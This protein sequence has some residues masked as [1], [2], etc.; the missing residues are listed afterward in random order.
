MMAA[1]HLYSCSEMCVYW[2]RRVMKSRIIRISL[3]HIYILGEQH[4]CPLPCVC[5]LTFNLWSL[6]FPNTD[7]IA[8]YQIMGISK[9]KNRLIMPCSLCESCYVLCTIMINSQAALLAKGAVLFGV[10]LSS[11]WFRFGLDM[12]CNLSTLR[13]MWDSFPCYE[14][15][16]CCG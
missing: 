7:N 16:N 14:S 4:S 15:Y 5:L 9:F 8:D 13:L 11:F 3:A 1:F 6:H 2:C 12:K 10:R